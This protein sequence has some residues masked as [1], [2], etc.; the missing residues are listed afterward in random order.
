MKAT[1]PLVVAGS[2]ASYTVTVSGISGIGSLGLNL[3]DNGSIHDLTGHPLTQANAA[4]SFQPQQTFA[5]RVQPV[6]TV[7]GELTGDGK[8][9][10]VVANY[11][12]NTIS[13][14]LGNGNGTFQAQHTFAAGL[15]P[16]SV[17]LGDVN[18]DNIPDLIVGDENAGSVSVL[19]GNGNGTFQAPRTFAAGTYPVSV[20]LGYLNGDGKP[21]LVVTNS[22]NNTV[23]VLLGNGNGT[24]Q[25]PQTFATGIAP[26]SVTVGELTGDGKEDLVVANYTSGTVSVLLG[27]GNGTFQAQQTFATGF[28]PVSVAVGDLNGDGNADLVVANFK[29]NTVS[30]LL[31]NGDG[32][33]QAQRTFAT[34]TEP[35]FVALGDMNG[36]GKADV[37]VANYGSN[38]ASVLL[39]NGNGTFES[40]KAF[41]TGTAPIAVALDDVNDD[42]RTDMIVSNYGSNTVSVL[43]NAINGNFTGQ[44]YTIE[45]QPM[46]T[47]QPIN[48]TVNAGG[49]TGFSAAAAGNPAP[50]VQWQVST[51]G[52]TSFTAIS[53]GG[54]YSGV[55]TDT[56]TITRATAAMNGYKY[57]A[58]FTNSLGRATT[59]AVTLTVHTAPAITKQPLSLTVKNGGVASFS[60]AAT[61]NPAPSVQWRVS[62]NGGVTFTPLGN[63][64]VYSGVTTDKLTITGVTAG[65]NGFRYEAVFTNSAGAATT[66]AATLTLNRFAPTITK[67]P[68]NQAVAAGGHASFTAA[69]SGNPTPTVQWYV[70]TNGGVSFT[71][72]TNGGVYSGARTDTL[73]I[74]GAT[75]AMNGYEY[76]AVFTNSLGALATA[77][78]T[79]MVT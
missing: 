5:T 17:A 27:N 7:V 14:L 16:D 49:S 6:A 57:E 38:T 35:E 8:E 62:A 69:A 46:I 30:A 9:D 44:V 11:K 71:P 2:G 37:V 20:Q 67:Q 78:A 25:A 29:S 52:G 58:V 70:S 1:S 10:L 48:A 33:F 28:S 51:N 32:T 24:F 50:T 34:G 75:L 66:S 21:D 18:G 76:E 55:T 3:V 63:G 23:S 13:V 77:D 72:I 19:L 74:T 54:A 4:A 12:S 45:T 73:T 65:M 31:G 47:T 40:Q 43:A 41:A 59:N 39:G 26:V 36:D 56:L 79:L 64:G 15:N 53:N 60:A 68:G 22:G 61:G 42:G